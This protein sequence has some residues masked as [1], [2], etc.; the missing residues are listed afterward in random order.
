MKSR[1]SFAFSLVEVTLAIGIVAFAV[2]ALVAL[3]P[4]GMQASRNASEE[5]RAI[6]LLTA[7][8]A[9]LRQS[10][11]TG[12]SAQF[13]I[14]PTPWVSG[15]SG[16]IE[17]NSRLAAGTPFVYFASEG[18]EI[19]ATTNSETR[20][21]VTLRYTRAP[22]QV[23]QATSQSLPL[24]SRAP[25]EATLTVSWPPA[26]ALNSTTAEPSGRVDLYLVFPRPAQ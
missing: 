4:V 26:I 19:S 5:H 18:Q 9:D 24:Y 22:G 23:D 2:L 16:G 11:V 17:P 15:T 25:A 6:D 1:F 8:A 14:A 20:Y 7:L 21:R 13:G 3:L 12:T 10:Q